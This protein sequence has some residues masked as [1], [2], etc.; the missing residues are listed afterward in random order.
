[1]P[2]DDQRVALADPLQAARELDAGPAATGGALLE[3][4]CIA[5]S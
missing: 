5:C 2:H 4:R 1:M 3:D